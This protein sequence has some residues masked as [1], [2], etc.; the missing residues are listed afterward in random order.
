[1]F[2]GERGK[3]PTHDLF[4]LTWTEMPH[5][6]SAVPRDVNSTALNSVR[7]LARAMNNRSYSGCRPW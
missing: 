1:M 2:I 7:E 4:S 3:R 5:G 6:G